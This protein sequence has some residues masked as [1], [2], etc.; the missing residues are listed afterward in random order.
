M[1]I[2]I[3]II[4]EYIHTHIYIY[5]YTHVQ[6]EYNTYILYVYIYIYIYTYTLWWINTD[7]EHLPFLVETN[8]PTPIW[9]GLCLFTGRYIYWLVVWNMFYFFHILGISSSQLTFI[10]FRGAG[11]PLTRPAIFYMLSFCFRGILNIRE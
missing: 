9:H 4:I 8:L 1:Y 10:V 5:V 6:E 3:H 2:C 7:P 11:I